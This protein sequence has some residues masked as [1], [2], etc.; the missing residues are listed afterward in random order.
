MP[1]PSH[2]YHR[3]FI[4]FLIMTLFISTFASPAS[5]ADETITSIEITSDSQTNKLSVEDGTI[6]LTVRAN[7]AGVTDQRIVTEDAAWTS[8]STS[9]KVNKGVLTATG[10]VT[11][12][13]IT[14][15]YKT[16]TA[17]I[18]VSADYA[19]SALKLK[20]VDSTA[21]APTTKNVNLGDDLAFTAW[22]DTM[23]VTDDATWT[24]SN[25][26]VATVEDGDVSL[27]TAGTTTITARS[28]GRSDTI[29]LTVTS[30]F[31]SVTIKDKDD[32]V[33]EAPIELEVEG[34][35]ILKAEAKWIDE[36]R[37]DLPNITNDA[38][39][40]SSNVSVIK[41]D[42]VTGIATAVGAG[43]ATLTAKRFGL[44]DAVTF[45]VRTPFEVMKV[46]PTKP[47]AITLYGDKVSVTA[48]VYKGT[49]TP[50]SVT[51]AAVWKIDNPAI[52][53]VEVTSDGIF[54]AP[55]GIGSTKVTATYKGI[56][57]EIAVTVLPT[58]DTINIDKDK[59]DVYT[60]DTSDLPAVS[61]VTIAGDTTDVSKLANWTSDKTSVISIE[62]GKWKAVAP[63]TAILTAKIEN[64][65]GVFRTDT[66]TVEV[67]NKVLAIIP[68]SDT[69]SV[70]IGKEADLPA[71]RLIYEDGEEEVITDKIVWKSSTANLLVKTTTM[72]GLLAA[73][74]VLTGTYL[75][76]TIKVKVQ[77]EEEFSSFLITPTKTSLTLNRTQSIKVVGTTK[78][79]KKI[80]VSTRIDWKASSDNQL[81]VNGASVKA[82]A[83][84]TGKLTATLQGKSLE[85]PYVV[86]AK[87][88]KLTTPT[89][90]YKPAIGE[91][92]SIV[93][94]ALYE[95]GKTF[96]VTTDAVWTTSKAAVATVKDGKITVVG[97]GSASIKAV[98][99]GKTVTVRISV[100]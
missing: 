23:N 71:V 3:M 60:G 81:E 15:K 57:K 30:P 51:Q 86:T 77:V 7:V 85:I 33:I 43:T 98:F 1:H 5:A 100:K 58:I 16:A 28:K 36:T 75:D 54:V 20:S 78:S 87:L 92:I 55:K 27:L 41:F 80:T 48:T 96:I 53:S 97:K 79:G 76:K 8:S 42:N 49:T 73:S 24:S 74:A 88:T 19:Y 90:S 62:D 26:T 31:E 14:A 69:M 50:N 99:A 70:V 21:D 56:T 25:T 34:T 64:E 46:T 47:I 39:W 95:N 67:H 72:K 82:I 83:E 11:T 10:A 13:T 40:T 65:Q 22:G 6:I 35:K 18:V 59:L 9:I 91:Q 44:S 89:T 93:L 38:V 29:A 12:A 37:V 4:L 45:I 66:I 52:A 17:S 63:G 68:D 61:G 94:S 84:G 32:K 2:V